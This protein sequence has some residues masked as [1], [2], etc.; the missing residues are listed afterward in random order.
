[1]SETKKEI[2]CDC[3]C[4]FFVCLYACGRTG[5]AEHPGGR[6]RVLPGATEP[7]GLLPALPSPHR[8]VAH[9]SHT[10]CRRITVCEHTVTMWPFPVTLPTS[11]SPVD[12]SHIQG[13]LEE[14]STFQQLLVQSLEEHTKSVATPRYICQQRKVDLL[15]S[16]R[17]YGKKAV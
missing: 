17:I 12:I 14:I 11:L 5:P 13:N 6:E 9:T 7:A 16:H 4:V 2:E 1:M 10:S 3:V 8:Q 15:S